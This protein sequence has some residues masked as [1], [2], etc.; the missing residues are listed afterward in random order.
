MGNT[1]Q[2]T[3]DLQYVIAND[4]TDGGKLPISNRGVLLS[5]LGNQLTG[6]PVTADLDKTIA[7]KLRGKKPFFEFEVKNLDKNHICISYQEQSNTVFV[8]GITDV[9]VSFATPQDLTPDKIKA[10]AV[11]LKPATNSTL[12]ASHVILTRIEGNIGNS[13]KITFYLIDAKN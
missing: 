8:V 3:S 7:D 5:V 1:A 12:M 2:I 11:K 10:T 6:S 9:I 13:K 4:C